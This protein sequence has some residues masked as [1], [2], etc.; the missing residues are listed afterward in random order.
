MRKTCTLLLTLVLCLCMT[1]TAFAD[2]PAYLNVN[3]NGVDSPMVFEDQPQEIN[4]VIQ[5][6]ATQGDA[7]EI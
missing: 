3:S 2:A 5:Q 7:D 4:V 6:A 1:A